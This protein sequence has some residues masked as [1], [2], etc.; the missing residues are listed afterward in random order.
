MLPQTDHKIPP[1]LLVL[2]LELDAGRTACHPLGHRDHV[3]LDKD[4]GEKRRSP[5]PCLSLREMRARS[6]ACCDNRAGFFRIA[7]PK[8]Q[9]RI[10]AHAQAD[11][12]SALDLEVPHHRG[13]VVDR[14][15]PA[16]QRCIFGD[17]TGW[18]APGIV[19]NATVATEEVTHL[20][21][22]PTEVRCE[23]VDQDD[24]ITVTTILDI[25]LGPISIDI[26]H[27]FSSPSATR[28]SGGRDGD[29]DRVATDPPLA[30]CLCVAWRG[31]TD[32]QGASAAGRARS[33]GSAWTSQSPSP[34]FRPKLQSTP[35]L[36][37]MTPETWS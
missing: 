20:G 2:V 25:E 24:R 15:L 7:Q 13:D 4:P 32:A 27:R 10:S 6:N 16:I 35:P 36:G 21:F 28:A 14:E 23:F 12:M 34:R 29:T 5:Q 1:A 26:W 9:G 30:S 11:Q 17:I 18:V 31:I 3:V 33:S 22:P 8:L 37:S 19:G